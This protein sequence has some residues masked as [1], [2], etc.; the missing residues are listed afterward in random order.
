MFNVIISGKPGAFTAILIDAKSGK[1]FL[2]IERAERRDLITE[3]SDLTT[4]L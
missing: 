3:I 1:H 2:K 4:D